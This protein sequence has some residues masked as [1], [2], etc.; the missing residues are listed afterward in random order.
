MGRKYVT[1]TLSARMSG[2]RFVIL[3]VHG[4]RIAV[5]PLSDAIPLSEQS[6]KSI[7]LRNEWKSAFSG[8]LGSLNSKRLRMLALPWDVKIQTWMTSLRHRRNRRSARYGKNFRYSDEKRKD[9]SHAVTCLLAQYNNKLGE[10]R[11]RNKNPWRLW[12]QTVAGNHR[13][14]G[15]FYADSSVQEEKERREGYGEAVAAQTG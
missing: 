13:K 12:A 7:E 9:W 2:D 11:L 6:I 14:K 4:K 1:V 5:L 15:C 3:D 8:M 10:Y